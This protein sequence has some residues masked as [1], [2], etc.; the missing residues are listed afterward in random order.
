MEFLKCKRCN[1]SWAPR[2]RFEGDTA[3][4]KQCPKCKQLTWETGLLPRK[5]RDNNK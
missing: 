1:Y 5:V 3:K 2:P 4:P